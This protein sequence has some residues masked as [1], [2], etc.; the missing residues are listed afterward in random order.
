[1]GAAF[2]AGCSAFVCLAARDLSPELTIIARARSEDSAGKIEKAG[3]DRIVTPNATSGVQ[4]ASLILR[5]GAAL[6]MDT[7]TPEGA[8]LLIDQVPVS[9]TSPMAGQTLAESEIAARTR[10]LLA[11]VHQVETEPGGDALLYNPDPRYR[12][13][14]GDELVVIG[15]P[16][17]IDALRRPL[18]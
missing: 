11:A 12:L 18:A 9:A 10:P 6:F 3:A 8:G 14:A 13:R 4:M 5:P 16:D 17:R 15:P 2:Q 7:V 1:M